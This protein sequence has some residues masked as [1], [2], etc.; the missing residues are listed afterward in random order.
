MSLV[1]K[2]SVKVLHFRCASIIAKRL[3]TSSNPSNLLS[4]NP[5]T[6]QYDELV[7]D[8]GRSGDFNAVRHLLDK[9]VKDGC[10]N[11]ANTFDFIT[12]DKA[13][14]ST[15]DNLILT[16]TRLDK[17]FTRKGAFDVLISRLCNLGKIDNSLR[18]I[19]T[20]GHADCGLNACSF[21]PI[22]RALTRRNR[23]DESWRVVDMMRS[24]GVSPDST[25]YNYLLMTHCAA[26]DLSSAATVLTRMEEQGMKANGRTYDALVLG[27]CRAG[28]VEGALLILRRMEDDGV[29]MLLSTRLYVVDAFL[30]LGYYEQ[31]VKFLRI[32]C[33]KDKWLDKESF[34]CLAIRFLKLNR[35]D[36]ARLVLEEM[37]KRGLEMRD[38]LKKFQENDCQNNQ[39]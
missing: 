30:S 34:G 36:E 14:L 26:G 18:V 17:G 20:M 10:Y 21:H 27:A 28:K 25:T 13:S 7:N 22:L 38:A 6:A 11:T 12:N 8:A 4:D 3:F 33:G 39:S 32:Y 31:A 2:A 19:E 15:L 9:R 5:T 23:I 37:K 29:P 35:M 24:L 1:H 16:L